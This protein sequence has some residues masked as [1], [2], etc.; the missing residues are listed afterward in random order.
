VCE[1]R[2]IAQ[3]RVLL[4]PFEEGEGGSVLQAEI[5][6]DT[7]VRRG[8]EDIDALLGTGGRAHVHRAVDAGEI[9]DRA[10]GEQGEQA[11]ARTFEHQQATAALGGVVGYGRLQ[12]Q[13]L[14]RS[15][16]PVAIERNVKAVAAASDRLG[17]GARQFAG[18]V[19]GERAAP[20]EF[21]L[22]GD[23][24]AEQGTDL[25]GDRQPESGAAVPAAERAVP[26]WK[27]P[28]IVLRFSV[29]MPMPVSATEKAS[30]LPPP[31][32]SRVLRPTRS[33]T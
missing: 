15:G 31:G 16:I 30:I 28:K 13:R 18:Q 20:A 9:G 7:L 26:C 3:P 4:E 1:Y 19:E 12:L 6:D 10:V 23:L 24:A 8:T 27:A 11:A 29:A 33:T 25:A 5:Q 14:D 22:R 32:A 2:D 21:A 17:R